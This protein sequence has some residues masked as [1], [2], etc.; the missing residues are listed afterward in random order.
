QLREMNKALSSATTEFQKLLLAARNEGAVAVADPAQLAGLD[1]PALAAAAAAAKER[2][3]NGHLLALQNTTQQPVLASLRDRD[4]R[5]RVLAASMARGSSGGQN[6]SRRLLL[7]I[8]ALRAE[9]AK[10]LG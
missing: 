4:L 3:V 10:L 1:E 8:A 7:R 6:D 2:G 5:A 9:K